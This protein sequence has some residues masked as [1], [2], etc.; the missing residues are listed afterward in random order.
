MPR[1]ISAAMRAALG[2]PGGQLVTNPI[3]LEHEIPREEIM[4]HVEAALAEV[5]AIA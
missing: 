5:Q 3:P 1:A 2:I 4:P